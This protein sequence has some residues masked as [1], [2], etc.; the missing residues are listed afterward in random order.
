MSPPLRPVPVRYPSS[1]SVLAALLILSFF[2]RLQ[3]SFLTVEG[4]RRMHRSRDI[5]GLAAALNHADPD[6]QYEAVE[7]LGDIRDPATVAPLAALFTADG[8]TAVRWKVA[9]A[10][11]RIGTPSVDPLVA[12]LSH[13]D[14]DVRWKAAIA[15]GEIKD[16]RA[17]EPL[18]R[19]LSDTDRFVKGRAALALGMIGEPAVEPLLRALS[20]GDGNQRWGAVIALGKIQD[21]RA[22]E[23][24]IRAL[25]DK[26]ENV[27]AE[28][29][30]ALA[31]IGE[32]AVE[33]LIRFLKYSEGTARIEVMNAL[34]DLQAA[35][36]I[37]PLIQL[38]ERA[39]EEERRTIAGV[40]DAI[41]TPT[42]EA[43]AKRLWNGDGDD[44]GESG[45]AGE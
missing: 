17:I 1:V 10:L 28:A 39:T 35:D 27:R 31:A 8:F 12:A 38:L 5:Q 43:I 45:H 44:T 9:E 2:D 7:A 37:E 15:L 13:P 25:A 21:P 19:L 30:A 16:S 41:L 24:L 42:A 22:I 6:I 36:A 26:Y 40:L 34:G 3:Q 20:E 33:P 14:D 18:V 11:A 29:A 23:P 4:I 32:P